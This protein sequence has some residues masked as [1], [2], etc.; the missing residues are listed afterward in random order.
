MSQKLSSVSNDS[1][2]IRAY[3]LYWVRDAVKWDSKPRRL[4][5]LRMNAKVT[6]RNS[7][8]KKRHVDVWTQRGVYALYSDGK[9]MYV[10]LADSVEGIG[11]RLYSHH[12]KPRLTGRWD[13]FSWF[14]INGFDTTGNLVEVPSITTSPKALIRA[15]ELIVILTA[16][17]LMNRAS[18][19]FA[20]A[21]RINQDEMVKQP[22]NQE[23]K[24]LLQ[25]ILDSSKTIANR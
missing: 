6:A 4:P 24:E 20:G 23:L 8:E 3:G 5:G 7:V 14:G 25:Q 15:L 21:E 1:S 17:P 13:A 22:T 11:D 19:K 18:G 12:T 2:L 16:D 9:L 10:G